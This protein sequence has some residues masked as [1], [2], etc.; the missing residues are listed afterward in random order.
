MSPKSNMECGKSQKKRKHK[1]GENIDGS[2]DDS[3]FKN[4]EST[5]EFPRRTTLKR[6]GMSP[7]SNMECG[8]SQKKRKHKSGEN[9]DGSADDSTFKNDESTDEFPRRTTLKRIG[10]SPKSNMEC[11]TSQKKRKHKSGEEVDNKKM[12][13]TISNII[14]D[15]YAFDDSDSDQTNVDEDFDSHK[16]NLNF[17]A[18]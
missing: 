6:I 8:T 5:D 10:M 4:D 3:T 9:I 14:K 2:A 11:G 16:G 13:E 15:I 17:C 12:K 1:S 18:L 7:K